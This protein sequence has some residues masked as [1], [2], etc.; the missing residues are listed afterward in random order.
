MFA[1]FV[2]PWP[3]A[4]VVFVGYD[5]EL[6]L[7]RQRLRVR[8]MQRDNFRLDEAER[9]SLT[10]MAGSLFAA[11][12]DV[13]THPNEPEGPAVQEVEAFDA[14]AGNGT[15]RW[16]RRSLSLTPPREPSQPA[17]VVR[18]VGRSWMPITEDHHIACLVR[19]SR[20][21]SRLRY[22]TSSLPISVPACGFSSGKAANATLFARG[23]GIC[24]MRDYEDLRRKASLWREALKRSSAD[25]KRSLRA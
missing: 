14:V 15:W 24:G 16:Q 4:H 11:S 10:S 3:S 17:Q 1:R 25:P 18:F 22:R 21:A 13:N 7:Y 19:L 5:F 8:Q 12:T 9:S 6:R 23:A 2:D 20:N